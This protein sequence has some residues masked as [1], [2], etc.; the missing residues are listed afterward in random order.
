MSKHYSIKDITIERHLGTE[1]DWEDNISPS[2]S[3][4]DMEE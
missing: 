2:P 4:N 3:F 1:W